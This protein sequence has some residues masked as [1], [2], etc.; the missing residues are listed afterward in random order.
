MTEENW[1][2]H[3]RKLWMILK[4]QH[5]KFPNILLSCKIHIYENISRLKLKA[6]NVSLFRRNLWSFY[7][8]LLYEHKTMK[9]HEAGNKHLRI[10]SSSKLRAQESFLMR[11][12]KVEDNWRKL[13]GILLNEKIFHKIWL[14][15]LV[16]NEKLTISRNEIFLI[17]FIT[18]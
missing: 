13:F 18:F 12:A 11:L 9:I 10:R 15:K 8:Y 2:K 6:S 4:P 5:R 7:L 17:R 3:T 14:D 1:L 16:P